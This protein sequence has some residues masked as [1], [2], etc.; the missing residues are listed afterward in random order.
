MLGRVLAFSG[1]LLCAS[2]GAFF[3]FVPPLVIVMALVATVALLLTGYM[4]RYCFGSPTD[5]KP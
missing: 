2:I 4:L 5:R 3:L 1:V